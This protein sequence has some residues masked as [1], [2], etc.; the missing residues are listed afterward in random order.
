MYLGNVNITNSTLSGNKAHRNGGA[1][2]VSTRN[3]SGHWEQVVQSKQYSSEAPAL[4]LTKV[5]MQDNEA[6]ANGGEWA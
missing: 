6:Q 4:S 5:V 2:F 3:G 1:I